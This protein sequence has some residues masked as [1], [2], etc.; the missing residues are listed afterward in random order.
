MSQD[1]IKAIEHI[2]DHAG[3][4]SRDLKDQG[5]VRETAAMVQG[6]SM[7]FH[8][9]DS[10]PPHNPWDDVVRVAKVLELFSP[11]PGVLSA[12]MIGA[13]FEAYLVIPRKREEW[14]KVLGRVQTTWVHNHICKYVRYIEDINNEAAI[15]VIANI[16]MAWNVVNIMHRIRLLERINAKKITTQKAY[17]QIM[18][19][20]MLTNLSN[21]HETYGEPHPVLHDIQGQLLNRLRSQFEELQSAA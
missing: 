20:S 6:A 7:T 11:E 17:Y 5:M 13:F 1:L 2:I 14:L 4:T 21:E 18:V 19:D 12:G 3:Y 10:L 16:R 15:G 9:P 8:R